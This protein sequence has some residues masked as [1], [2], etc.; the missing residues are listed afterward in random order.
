MRGEPYDAD[1]RAYMHKGMSPSQIDARLKKPPGWAHDR[2]V[3]WW[4]WE[5]WHGKGPGLELGI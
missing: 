1:V 2:V 3:E 4:H 5:K